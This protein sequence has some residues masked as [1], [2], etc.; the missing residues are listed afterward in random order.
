LRAGPPI[1]ITTLRRNPTSLNKRPVARHESGWSTHLIVIV[2]GLAASAAVLALSYVADRT[3]IAGQH[4]DFYTEVWPSYVALTHGHLHEFARLGPAYIGS[5]VLRAPFALLPRLWGAGVEATYLAS[6]VPCMM[7]LVALCTWL[8]AQPRRQGGVGWASRISVLVIAIFNPVVLVLLLD[9]HPE[10]ILG[11]VLCIAGIVAAVRGRAGW[12]GLLIGLAVVNKP[13]AL[14]AVPVALAVMPGERRRAVVFMAATGAAVLLPIMWLQNGGV[15]PASAGGEVGTIFNPPQLLWWFGRHAFVVREAHVIIVLV[16]AACA[17]VWWFSRRASSRP[18][19]A[20]SEALLLLAF[21]L[22]L[23]AALDPWNNIYYHL[24]F[25][26]AM[27]TYE[28]YSGRMPLIALVSSLIL[29]VIVPVYGILHV[30]VDARAAIYAAVV[31]PTL[32]FLAAKVYRTP[33]SRGGLTVLIPQRSRPAHGD[34]V[35]L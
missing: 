4:N 1:T 12:T 32:G 19:A 23:R 11:A 24:P 25:M 17:A 28:I 13:W 18:Q 22:L 2:L 34:E 35:V 15:N 29:F 3:T 33:G 27:M 26:L 6:T 14:V 5:T 21:V 31:L 30:S 10:E 9:G 7:A 16:A 20:L 8:A